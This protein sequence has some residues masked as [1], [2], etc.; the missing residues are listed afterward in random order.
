MQYPSVV[1]GLT[2]LVSSCPSLAQ[3]PPS[4]DTHFELFVGHSFNTDFVRD[5]PVLMIADQKVSP[6]FSNGSG[7]FGFEASVKRYIRDG[8]GIKVAVSGY[9]DPFFEGSATYCQPTACAVDVHA[10]A[11]PRTFYATVGPEWKFRR[12]KRISP[13][14]FALGG[15]VYARS[16]FELSG[17][18]IQYA[19]GYKQRGLIVFN[20]AGFPQDGTV[21]YSDSNSDVGLALGLG[22]GFETR[23]S[24]R[25]SFRV[26]MN[27]DPTFLSRPVVTNPTLIQPI[28]SE[29]FRQ[30]HVALSLGLG[31]GIR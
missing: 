4:G 17:S 18:N 19:N 5:Q 10:K 16:T 2:I 31:W 27:Y 7:P 20:S 15:L 28:R 24:K 23:L 8:M 3:R 25:F 1:V 26:S 21:K 11:D 12:T 29:K 9:F 14:V 6:F 13:F 22:G 30:D